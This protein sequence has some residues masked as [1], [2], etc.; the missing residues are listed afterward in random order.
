VTYVELDSTSHVFDQSC[1]LYCGR[2]AW[3]L[4]AGLHQTTYAAVL[5]GLILPQVRPSV[6]SLPSTMSSAG[7]CV[8]ACC[9]RC[10][11]G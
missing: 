1:D 4:Y 2:F 8:C 9:Q 7:V 11:C 10:A 6:L 5:L 3:Y